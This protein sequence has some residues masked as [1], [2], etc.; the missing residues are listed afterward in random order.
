MVADAED[1]LEF[2]ESGVGMFPDVC[3]EFEG[4]EFSP[5]TP[6]CFGGQRS[7]M[8]GVQIAVN[9]ASGEIE[10]SGGLGF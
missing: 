2:L 1:L 5:M 10:A 7:R 8:F 4:V 3:A 9:G 6:A